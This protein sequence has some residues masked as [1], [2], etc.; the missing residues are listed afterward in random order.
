MYF[1]R[2]TARQITSLDRQNLATTISER[3][4]AGTSEALVSGVQ[5]RSKVR[6]AGLSAKY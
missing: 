2:K 3:D 4:I 1:K 5:G 6:A